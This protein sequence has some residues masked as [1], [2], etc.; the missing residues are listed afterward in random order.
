M[1]TLTYVETSRTQAGIGDLLVNN[2]ALSL[3]RRKSVGLIRG[4]ALTAGVPLL[5]F[6]F[7]IGLPLIGF[8][9]MLL[10]ALECLRGPTCGR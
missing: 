3:V 6:V 8:V 9:A 5:G 2:Q 7:V 4:V 1:T 10:M